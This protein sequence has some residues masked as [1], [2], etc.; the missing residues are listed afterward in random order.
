MPE[1]QH[2]IPAHVLGG[3]A[4]VLATDLDGPFACL[5]QAARLMLDQGTG[6]TS[7]D[8]PRERHKSPQS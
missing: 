5:Q 6:P 2:V 3:M 8:R 7:F 1:Q 4:A